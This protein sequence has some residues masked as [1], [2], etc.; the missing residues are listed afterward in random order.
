[1]FESWSAKL[2][3]AENKNAVT[4]KS[5]ATVRPTA[6]CVIVVEVVFMVFPFL[7]VH[8]FPVNLVLVIREQ[9]DRGGHKA[10]REKGFKSDKDE[11][12][13]RLFTKPY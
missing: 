10:L 8:Y 7:C 9:C 12:K 2:S 13:R 3:E 6:V 11:G 1:M 4:D 5:A